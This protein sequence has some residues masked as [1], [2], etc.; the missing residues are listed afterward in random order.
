MYQPRLNLLVLLDEK[1]SF[2]LKG[3][4]VARVPHLKQHS[5]SSVRH[6]LKDEAVYERER[7]E[8]RLWEAART[9]G[10]SRRRFLQ[11]IGAGFVVSTLPGGLLTACANNRATNEETASE[12]KVIKP[13]SSDYF[14]VYDGNREMRWEAMADRG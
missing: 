8:R 9:A 3:R 5:D 2:L 13:T 14:Y 6:D 12:D 4:V 7:A 1:P 11:L 10:I